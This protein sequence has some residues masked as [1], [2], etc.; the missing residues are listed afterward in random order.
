M[1]DRFI[2]AYKEGYVRFENVNLKN[3]CQ[4]ILKMTM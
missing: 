3:I 1:F 2:K 4:D